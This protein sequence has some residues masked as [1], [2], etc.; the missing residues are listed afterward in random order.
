MKP[1]ADGDTRK[2][3]AKLPK[4]GGP[5]LAVIDS[6][7]EGPRFGADG[8]SIP[9]KTVPKGSERIA[10]CKLGTYY[11]R[12]P[13][14]GRSLFAA[15]EDPKKAVLKSLRCYVAKGEGEKWELDGIVWKSSK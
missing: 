9:L 11:E 12:M 3:A 7:G 8:L 4:I 1:S 6:P 14:G 13:G 15:G 10:K 5:N 2:R